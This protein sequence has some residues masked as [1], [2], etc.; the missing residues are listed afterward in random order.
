[1]KGTI[2]L[3]LLRAE[4]RQLAAVACFQSIITQTASH[5]THSR[6]IFV[7]KAYDLRPVKDKSR[8]GGLL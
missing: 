3:H 4:N 2:P 7:L 1:M 6:K 5:E 8:A